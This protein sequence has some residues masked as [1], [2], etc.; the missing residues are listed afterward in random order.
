M[1]GRVWERIRG[2]V[3]GMKMRRWMAWLVCACML[4]SM[5][6]CTA[7]G[8][9]A[10]RLI[11]VEYKKGDLNSDWDASDVTQITF[12]GANAEIGGP[13]ASLNGGVLTVFAEGD[14]LLMGSFT[15]RIVVDADKKDKV[16]L[17]LNGLTVDSGDSAAIFVK[18]ADKATLVLADG[19]ENAVLSGSRL[20]YADDEE[21]DAAIYSKSDLVIN[22]GGSLSV[23][24]PY[25]HGILSKDDLRLIEGAV[26]V[27]AAEDG[28]RGRDAVQMAGGRVSVM[29]AGDGV[30]SNNDEDADKGYISID[31]G[32]LS[33]S[34]GEDGI[35]AETMLQVTGGRVNVMKSEEGM[36]A[37]QMLIAG[38]EV[39][40][41]SLDDG[42]NASG[43]DDDRPY[44]LNDS[45][46]RVT[47]GVLRVNAGG[48]GIDSNGLLRIE[49]GEVYVSGSVRGDNGALDASGEM[50]L[51]G[52][53]LLACG[54][55][56]MA[57][58]P[59]A[60]GQTVTMMMA[61]ASQPGGAEVSVRKADGTP[62]A[63]FT[64]EKEWASLVISAPGVEKGEELHVYAAGNMIGS[65]M[66]GEVQ[67]DRRGPGR[68]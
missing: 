47:G 64:P 36:E 26:T 6:A 39:S 17:I 13:G 1:R 67:A 46:I 9:T 42:V 55:A 41:N 52:G 68:W 10:D 53:V 63:A 20:L 8:E 32:E 33:V 25:G 4:L 29:A 11:E 3:I 56:G 37:R 45:L 34:A 59:K 40:V 31:G 21:L 30:K 51:S 60:D 18:K 12:G 62:L 49:G 19:S 38:G 27:N 35:K 23:D 22:G 58:A 50:S 57:E 7:A 16:R 43:E 28:I 66:A 5:T 48:D 65:I 61:A 24:S 54:A 2:E 44:A 15:G 14:Y